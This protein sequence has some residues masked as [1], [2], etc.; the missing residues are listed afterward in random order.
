MK[1]K[2]LSSK[3]VNEEHLLKS[4]NGSLSKDKNIREREREREIKKEN[5]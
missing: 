5:L 2:V 3:K 4:S 1:E